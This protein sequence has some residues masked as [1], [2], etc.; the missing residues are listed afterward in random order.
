MGAV[1]AG[2][3]GAGSLGTAPKLVA[4]ARRRPVFERKIAEDRGRPL[5]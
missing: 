5:A 4:L 3:C 2:A 1:F